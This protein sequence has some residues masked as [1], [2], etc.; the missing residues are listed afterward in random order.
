MRKRIICLSLSFAIIVLGCLSMF[1]CTNNIN[2]IEPITDTGTSEIETRKN[3]YEIYTY[4][5]GE[6][7]PMVTPDYSGKEL[8]V[9]NVIFFIL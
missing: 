9:S 6:G 4:K 7:G 8:F 3:E 2:I 1:S 5:G